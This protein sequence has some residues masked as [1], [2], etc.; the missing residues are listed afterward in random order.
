MVVETSLWPRSSWIGS[1]VVAG[2][3]EL[4]S[5]GV[6]EAVAARGLLDRGRAE[7]GFEGP[8]QNCLVEVMATEAACL[9]VAV[10]TRRREAPVPCELALG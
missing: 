3:E 2:P 6:A 9:R 7:G 8:L 10:E 5:E 4:G 1:E